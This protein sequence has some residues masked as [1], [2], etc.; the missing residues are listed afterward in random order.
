MP[1]WLYRILVVVSV[2]GFVM[3]AAAPTYAANGRVNCGVINKT[4]QYVICVDTTAQVGS[5]RS[6]SNGKIGEK[7]L[8]AFTVTTS[9]KDSDG[10]NSNGD[11]ITAEGH[12]MAGTPQKKTSIGLVQYIPFHGAQGIHAYP[13]VG[14][15]FDSHGCVRVTQETSDAIWV[16]LVAGEAGDLVSAGL[17]EFHI[18]SQPKKSK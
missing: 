8:G 1:R 4:T 13:N 10:P 16:L 7:V 17:V 3:N 14:L 2:F 5:V 6:A 15:E 11:T 18:Y 12:F 9:R